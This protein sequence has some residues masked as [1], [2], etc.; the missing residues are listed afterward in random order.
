MKE[1]VIIGVAVAWLAIGTG[2][3]KPATDTKQLPLE[4]KPVKL[5]VLPA[6]TNTNVTED[7]APFVEQLGLALGR[8]VEIWV[9]KDYDA[10]VDAVTQKQV[11]LAQLSAYLYVRAKPA[12]AG[13]LLAQQRMAWDT[14]YRGVFVVNKESPIQ[15]LAELEHKKVAYVDR[16]S[17]AGY[18]YPRMRLRELG[19]NPDTFFANQIFAGSHQHAAELVGKGT[20]DVAT[21]SEQTL[22]EAIS[23]RAIERTGVIPDDAIVSATL[24]PD[25]AKKVR[26]FLLEAHKNPSLAPFMNRRGI[27]TFVL[28]NM[29]VYQPLE[30]EMGLTTTVSAPVAQDDGSASPDEPSTP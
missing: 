5:G 4:G 12:L 14:E 1:R 3:Q 11:D 2:C 13:E 22:P 19:H 27:E 24:S 28:P 15:S 18:Y 30:Q 23:L 7:Y 10:L 17:S 8:P 21:I 20:V 6:S 9:A 29:D 25:E 26:E 16:H